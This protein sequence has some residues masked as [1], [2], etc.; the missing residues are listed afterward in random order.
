MN[1]AVNI[2]LPRTWVTLVKE[3]LGLAELPRPIGQPGGV[4]T[5]GQVS[6]PGTET[7]AQVY[8]LTP[9][10]ASPVSLKGSYVMDTLLVGWDLTFVK[11]S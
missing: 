2:Y 7:A 8:P 4:A 9:D 1:F 6:Q 11:T 3:S 5:D 10:S